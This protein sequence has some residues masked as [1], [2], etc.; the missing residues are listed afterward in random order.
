MFDGNRLRPVL[1]FFFFSLQKLFSF[2]KPK[3]T[4]SNSTR[5]R[6][7]DTCELP[8]HRLARQTSTSSSRTK[9]TSFAKPGNTTSPPNGSVC[10]NQTYKNSS[11]T[12]GYR[13]ERH[14]ETLSRPYPPP[15][16]PPG[17]TRSFDR[18]FLRTL[19]KVY[20]TIERNEMRQAEQEQK[21]AI[22][23]E[24]Q[25]VAMVIDRVLLIIFIGLTVGITLGIVFRA[26]HALNFFL[27][28]GRD[29]VDLS[30]R[31]DPIPDESVAP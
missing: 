2:K 24:W 6:Y 31:A 23:R 21:D 3:L 28:V 17:A 30:D 4:R 9:N 18:T 27:G 1:I 5:E 14:G 19:E 13:L 26:P 15:D 11:P 12:I 20:Q 29:A 25:H 7:Y 10:S 22:K 8:Q 16:S